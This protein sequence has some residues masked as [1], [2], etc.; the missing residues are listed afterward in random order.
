MPAISA[1]IH[2]SLMPYF[3]YLTVYVN[4]SGSYQAGNGTWHDL[5]ELGDQGW[6]LV[7]VVQDAAGDLVAFFKRSRES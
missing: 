4:A 6:E 1:V 7:S 5:Q 3:D 2:Q